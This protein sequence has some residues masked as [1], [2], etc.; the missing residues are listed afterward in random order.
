MI[1]LKIS[2]ASELVAAK[3]GKF[4]ERLTP[5]GIDNS[6]VEDQV[7]KKMI[8]SLSEEGLKGE[9]S[10]VNSIDINDE[11]LI[12]DEGFKVRSHTSF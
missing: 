4:V 7:I 10:A 1:F 11:K 2:N 3:V 9:I 6:A 12:I 8:E 5:D